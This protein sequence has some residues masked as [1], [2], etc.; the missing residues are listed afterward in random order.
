MRPIDKGS[1]PQVDNRDKIVTNYRDWRYNLINRIGYYCAYCNMALSHNLQVEH[2]VPK[3]PMPGH[4]VGS[5]L[6]WSN[7]LIACGPCNNAK[8]NRPSD[9]N[10]HYLPE[11]HNCLLPF[12]AMTTELKQDALVIGVNPNLNETQKEKAQSTINYF[13][14]QNLDERPSIVDIRYLRRYK[15][16]IEVLAAR[17]L[18]EMAKASPTYDADI[19]GRLVA[20]QAT[21]A[22]FFI[23]WFHEFANEPFVLKWLINPDLFP[24]VAQ[25]CFDNNFNPI[26]RNP[27]NIDDPI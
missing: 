5:R 2:V 10:T 27:T 21:G 17:K 15:A 14:W 22:G 8:D 11:Y 26:P 23:L 19:A 1:C 25:N 16:Q 9:E 20:T 4:P 3:K 7:M 13:E 24:G 6:E 12:V 18:L